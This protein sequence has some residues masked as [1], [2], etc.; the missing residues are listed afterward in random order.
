[1]KKIFLATALSL[2]TF[3]AH[4]ECTITS[5]QTD[6]NM[7]KFNEYR[8][9]STENGLDASKFNVVCEKLHRAHARI[10]I[11]AFSTVLAGRSIGW[12][13]VL[14][15]D[16]SSQIVA[17]DYGSVST[18]V[19]EYASQDKADAIMVVAMNNAVAAWSGLDIALESLDKARKQ[20]RAHQPKP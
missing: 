20:V 9:W 7:A 5:V 19:N 12:A 15:M 6:R 14:V 11:S 8:G 18:M 17:T 4:S 10:N 1:M 3:A 13:Q 2:L 16:E